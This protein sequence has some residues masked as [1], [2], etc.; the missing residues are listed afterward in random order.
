METMQES[1]SL[2][3]CKLNL[4]K[5]LKIRVLGLSSLS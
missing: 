1:W 5:T 2:A 4:H 3:D